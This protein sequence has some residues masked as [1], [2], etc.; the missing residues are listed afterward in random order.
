MS[1]AIGHYR[2]ILRRSIG[3]RPLVLTGGAVLAALVVAARELGSPKVFVLATN[4]DR[5]GAD[6]SATFA[7]P[8]WRDSLD[9]FDPARKALVLGNNFYDRTE[10]AGRRFIGARPKQ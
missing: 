9:A 1:E 6:A 4:A 3:G 10:L 5:L 8:D 7:S 2:D